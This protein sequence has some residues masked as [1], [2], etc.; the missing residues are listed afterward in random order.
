LSAPLVLTVASASAQSRTT[1]LACIGRDGV[2][3]DA[4]VDVQDGLYRV[5]VQTYRFVSASEPVLDGPYVEEG[6]SYFLLS[7]LAEFPVPLG[8]S[9]EA[10]PGGSAL[11]LVYFDGDGI[12]VDY[13]FNNTNSGTAVTRSCHTSFVVRP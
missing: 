6:G 13:G 7:T 1:F 2:V 10:I 11:Q 9:A 5:P 3:G 12:P 8:Y 4:Y